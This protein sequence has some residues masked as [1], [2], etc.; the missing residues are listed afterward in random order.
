MI[1]KFLQ[2][3]FKTVGYSFFLKIYGKIEKSIDPETDDRVEVKNIIF[4][5]NLNYK[6]YSIKKGRLYTNRVQDTAVIIDNLIVK[7]PSFQFRKAKDLEIYD[8]K[9]SDNIVFKQGTPR[10]LKNLNGTVLSLLAGG[11]ANSNY[12]HWLFDVLPRLRLCED[13]INLNEIDYFLLPSNQ[14]KFQNESLNYLNIP[15]NKRLSSEKFRHI[16]ANKLLTTDHPVVTTGN[17]TT[18]IHRGIPNWISEWLKNSFIQKKE[19]RKNKKRSK[20]FI[21]RKNLKNLSSAQRAV[22]NEQE[23]KDYLKKKEF[24]FVNLEE[25]SFIEQVNLFNDSE[26]IVGLHGAGFANVVFCDTNT[27]IIEFKSISSGTSIE[28]LSKKNN[29][30][31]NSILSEAK[32]IHSHNTP[33][34]VWNQQ[35]S[36]EVSMKKLKEVLEV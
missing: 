23:I 2:N 36:I 13:Y 25:L 3:I 6:I 15:K 31:Y 4:E 26:C 16:K 22:I 11:G 10:V 27:K 33:T 35:G 34:N 18:D 7:G 28:N 17:A 9:I 30:N 14:N 20:I 12:W 8:S 29:L 1:K 5:K 32:K 21:N 19:N 24:T